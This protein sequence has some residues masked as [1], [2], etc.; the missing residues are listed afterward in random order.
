MPQ[1]SLL[2]FLAHAICLSMLACL[3]VRLPAG[4]V[5]SKPE[6]AGLPH[7]GIRADHVRLTQGCHCHMLGPGV[8]LTGQQRAAV[9]AILAAT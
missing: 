2:H 3:A 9:Q 4:G 1:H 6:A 8:R 7:A 5:R